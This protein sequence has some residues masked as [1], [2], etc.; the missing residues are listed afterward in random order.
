MSRNH[1]QLVAPV[2]APD[3]VIRYATARIEARRAYREGRI[4]D[5]DKWNDAARRIYEITR[6]AEWRI[7][8]KVIAALV[9]HPRMDDLGSIMILAGWEAPP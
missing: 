9:Q 3:F 2:Q 4:G 6:P 7:L 1:I 8:D 5:C